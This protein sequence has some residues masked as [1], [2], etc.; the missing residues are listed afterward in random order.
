MRSYHMCR[1]RRYIRNRELK[2][3]P[4]K[5]RKLKDQESEWLISFSDE[6]HH[7][8]ENNCGNENIFAGYS[9]SLSFIPAR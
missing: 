1:R 9:G 6:Q 2:T 4:E 8:E 7:V 5:L 3:D